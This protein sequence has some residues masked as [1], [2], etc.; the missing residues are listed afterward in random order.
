MFGKNISLG[1]KE[2]KITKFNLPI[3]VMIRPE[4][5]DVVRTNSKI[6]ATVENIL[7]KGTVYEVTCKTKNNNIIKIET[8]KHHDIGEVLKLN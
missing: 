4:D 1:P 8:V 2:R 5:I 7:Y 6:L 3:N